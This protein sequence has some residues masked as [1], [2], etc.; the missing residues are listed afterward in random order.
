[1]FAYLTQLI[2]YSKLAVYGR[3]Y[4]LPKYIKIWSGPKIME[5]EDQK[6][7]KKLATLQ[8]GTLGKAPLQKTMKAGLVKAIR[9]P[10]GGQKSWQLP[11]PGCWNKQP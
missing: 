2:T 4:F 3:L 11:R 9:G 5:G 1:M 10:W 6:A 8:A 7:A